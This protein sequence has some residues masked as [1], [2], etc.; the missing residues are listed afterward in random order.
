MLSE[1]GSGIGAAAGGALGG[2]SD[3]LSAPRRGLWNLVAQLGQAAGVG[4][5]T[6]YD[7]GHELLTGGL[8]MD[9][10]NPMTHI[11]GFGAEMLTDPLSFL[12]GGIGRMA[13]KG[14][15]AAAGAAK[16]GKAATLAG[17][18]EGAAGGGLNEAIAK[19]ASRAAGSDAAIAAHLSDV[20]TSPAALMAG[21]SSPIKAMANE[22]YLAG[23]KP[24]TSL[25]DVL[26]GG[27][28]EVGESPVAKFA[29]LREM[30][31]IDDQAAQ[32]AHRRMPSAS[33]S[34]DPMR[35]PPA[36]EARS[37]MAP[38]FDTPA[39][40]DLLDPRFIG[41]RAYRDMSTPA[42]GRVA[43]PDASTVIPDPARLADRLARFARR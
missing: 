37:A 41:S 31:G 2:I 9:A 30:S 17:R 5:G 28:A 22:R 34:V 29:N 20:G 13:G 19:S 25:A 42:M 14:M 33:L 27:A 15:E 7:S 21:R 12:G 6:A 23:A 3:V 26:G 1:I 4:D 40:N 39:S 32:L 10:D 36:G 18:L 24:Q 43:A 35:M 16:A 38:I 11:L 8:G